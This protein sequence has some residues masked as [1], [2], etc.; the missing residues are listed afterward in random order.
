MPQRVPTILRRVVKEEGL[1]GLPLYALG[2]SSGG[3][4]VLRLA[5]AMPEVQ[6]VICQINPVNPGV[7]EVKGRPYPPTVFVHMAAR[8]PEKAETVTKA[9]AIL[10]CVRGHC[11]SKQ[12]VAA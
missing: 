3:G 8:D 9:L 7:F 10:R 1:Q 4:F 12:H 11:C 2:A 6:G 5:Q